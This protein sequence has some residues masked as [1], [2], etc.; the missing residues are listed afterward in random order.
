MS[1]DNIDPDNHDA[2]RQWAEPVCRDLAQRLVQRQV[3]SGKVRMEVSWAAPG[4]IL[5]GL[6]W[7]EDHPRD[8][9]WVIGGDAVTPD[10]IP[11]RVADNP[12]DAARY[13]ALRWQMTGARVGSTGEAGKHPGLVDWAGM[14]ERF[15]EQAEMLYDLTTRD[16]LWEGTDTAS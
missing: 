4:R 11:K 8:R 5:L 2:V 13:F 14:E 16:D 6:A 7:D 3:L 15:V 9:H 10:V 12:R 1:K